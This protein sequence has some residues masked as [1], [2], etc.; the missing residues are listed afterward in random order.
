MEKN[1]KDYREGQKLTMPGSDTGLT[2]AALNLI[3]GAMGLAEDKKSAGNWKDYDFTSQEVESWK[4]I[5]LNEQDAEFAAYLRSKGHQPSK[6]L[7]IEQLREEYNKQ[8]KAQILQNQPNV[9]PSNK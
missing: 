6:D 8:F 4:E 5:G 3:S 1:N 7:N 2:K 9:S